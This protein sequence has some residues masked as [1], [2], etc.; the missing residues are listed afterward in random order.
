M[1]NLESYKNTIQ[2]YAESKINYSFQTIG[3]D[4]ALAVLERII[5]SSK[6]TVRYTTDSFFG[7]DIERKMAFIEALCTFLSIPDSRLSIIVTDLPDDVSQKNPYN[8]FYRLYQ[9]KAYSE[10]RVTIKNARGG[11][12]MDNGEKVHFCV[13]DSVMYRFESD[14]SKC[15]ASCNFNDKELSDKLETVFEN[16]FGTISTIVD[17]NSIFAE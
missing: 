11:H 1:E 16:A 2:Q 4:Y 15:I 5:L 14:T 13:A 8:P 3:K 12:F 6:K 7:E 10:G 17:L 9:H